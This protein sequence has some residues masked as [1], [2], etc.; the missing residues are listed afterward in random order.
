MFS[1][2]KNT[3]LYSPQG[4]GTPDQW[5]SESNQAQEKVMVFA[6]V[7]GSGQ[8]FGPYFLKQGVNLDQFGYKRLLRHTVFPDMRRALGLVE[9]N[10]TIWQHDGAKP[11]TA[12]S[13]MD[14][15]DRVFGPNK[16][17]VRLIPS[18]IVKAAVLS[19]KKRALKL[20]ECQGEAFE[21]RKVRPG[22]RV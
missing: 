5:F 20:V 3:V 12:N 4:E 1:Y 9:F 13:V 10:S 22:L 15:L 18:E 19:S 11:H 16:E 6:F 14:Y 2:R 21:G 8:V 17:E 7:H